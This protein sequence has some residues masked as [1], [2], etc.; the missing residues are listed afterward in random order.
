MVHL[1]VTMLIPPLL[2]MHKTTF[3]RLTVLPRFYRHA[4]L[5]ELNRHA[6]LFE[7]NRHDG[8]SKLQNA[9]PGPSQNSL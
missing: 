5:L 1:T 8:L 9:L 2:V 7:L 4:G 6:G 3:F